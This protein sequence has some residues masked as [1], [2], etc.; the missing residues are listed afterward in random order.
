MIRY[1]ATH[2]RAVSLGQFIFTNNTKAVP[3]E[4]DLAIYALPR[5]ESQWVHIM[6]LRPDGT[7]V[8]EN[9]NFASVLSKP[10]NRS[11]LDEVNN[12][13]IGPEKWI[14]MNRVPPNNE[15]CICVTNKNHRETMIGNG[16]IPITAETERTILSPASMDD[17]YC[18]GMSNVSYRRL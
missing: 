3:S 15:V 5:G 12:Y 4:Q 7:L 14:T 1:N 13:V 9:E 10:E 17:N 8:I 16:I 11:V 6:T 18:Q 2:E